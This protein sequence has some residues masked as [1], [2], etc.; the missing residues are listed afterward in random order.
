MLNVNAN[1]P[2]T[3]ETVVDVSVVVPMYN[4]VDSVEPLVREVFGV[5][6]GLSKSYEVLLID[7][8]SED[9]SWEKLMAL[10]NEFS[11]LSLIRFRRNFGQT[12]A[13]SAGFQHSRGE[14]I[15][16][17]DADMQNDPADIPKLLERM[18]QGFDV[19]SGW[20]KNRQDRALDRRLPSILA[21]LLIRKITGVPLHDF[22]CTLKA[23]RRDVIRNVHLYGEMHRFI[24]AL[25][26]WVG[27]KVDEV[28]VN[29]RARRFGHS[30]YG[31]SRTITVILD[32]ITVR[33]LLR[34]STGPIQLFG[35]MAGIFALPGFL[36]LL[37][38]VTANASFHL[39]GTTVG[40]D[41]IKR[42]FWIM[43]S[44]MLLFMG[45]Q[46][47]SMGLLA[48]VQIRTYHESQD[49]PTYVIQ[50]KFDPVV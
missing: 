40:A 20:R 6:E 48:E 16:T 33:F 41:L 22:G 21:N 47:V 39:L 9:G 31:I 26:A 12:A 45:M 49:K 17:L 24:P 2:Q 27:G 19:V 38:M 36:M 44:F 4:E 34:Y 32:L 46:L 28:V 30:K 10:R 23:Y 14:V 11:R 42:P 5:L 1:Q 25:A 18:G 8:G 50:E 43:T 37:F 29:H 15:I 3:R 13:I 35:K 7:D